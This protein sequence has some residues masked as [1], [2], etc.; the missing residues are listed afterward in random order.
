MRNTKKNKTTA[1]IICL[2]LLLQNTAIQPAHAVNSE[3]ISINEICAKNTAY[4]ANDGNYFD[5][6][7]LYNNGDSSS[8]ISGWGLS[9]QDDQPFKY[10][11]P[12]GTQIAAGDRIIVFCD[13][14]AAANN[15]QI[16]PFGLSASG[17][18]IVLTK[19]NGDTAQSV[20]FDALEADTSYGQYPEGSG[21]YFV[22]SCSPDKANTAPE[23]I[24]SVHEPV[25]SHDSGFYDNDFSLVLT[26]DKDC[27]I[28]YTTDG[29]DPSPEN[30]LQYSEP[31]TIT[32]MSD[33]E[34]RLSARTDIVP[35]NADKPKDKVDKAAVIR[36]VS[37]DS[38]GQASDIVT[39]TFFVGKTNSGYYKDM[40]VVSLITDPDNLFD[41]DKG[42]YCLGKIY[43]E[44]RGGDRR[45]PWELKANYSMKGREWERP[46]NFTMF[47]NG[48][49]V[50]EQ[51]IGIRIKGNYSR[52]LP[53]KSFNLY[54]RKE[55]GEEE[56][57]YD[58]FSGKAVKAKN[59]KTIKKYDGLTLRNGGNDNSSAFFRD[60]INQTLIADR[61]FAKQAATECIVF[62]DGE[63]W[64]IYQMMEKINSS[65]FSQHYG[66]DENSVAMIENGGLE[67]GNDSDLREWDELCNN[68][69]NGSISYDEFCK[70][71]DV[72][73]FIDYFASQIYWCNADWPQ[74]NYTVWRSDV[75]DESNPYADG[76]WR[77]AMFDT[78]SGQGL[79]GSQDK[80]FSA[81]QFKRIRESNCQLSKLFNGLINSQEF[82]YQFTRT[83]MDLSNQNFAADRT[84]EVIDFY[85]NNYTQQISDTFARFYSR[86]MSGDNAARHFKEALNTVTEFYSKRPSYAERTTRSAMKISSEP[87]TLSIKNNSNSGSIDLNT[88]KL[89]NISSWSGNYHSDYELDLTAK[90][91]EGKYFAYWNINDAE[92]TD[93]DIYSASVSLKL[94]S[95]ATVEAVYGD[96]SKPAV[97]TTAAVTTAKTTAAATVTTTVNSNNKSGK[98]YVG[99]V[100]E[101]ENFDIKSGVEN[102]NCS[103]GGMDAA[104]IEKGDYIGFNNI[105]L[106]NAGKID[107]RIG[108]NGARAALEVRIDSPD[109][110]VI[111]RMDVRSSDGWQTWNTQSCSIEKTQ[112]KHDLYF[113][114]TGEEGYLFN[115]NWWRLDSPVTECIIGDA[116]SDGIV[117]VFDFVI[118]KNAIENGLTGNFGAAD[119]NGD[120]AV[121]ETDAELI[122]KY[123]MGEI[124]SF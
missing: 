60:T 74:K 12:N 40:K 22:L 68:V 100:I 31:I 6:I 111:G 33:T 61:D 93:G 65:Y 11:F 103:E 122:K 62:V 8:D 72:Q 2:A 16:A 21:E 109:G 75:I 96:G 120:D 48:Q 37:V 4:A 92:I 99:K 35:D 20:S 69:G 106:S 71:V 9:D 66:V 76:K 36:A 45:N 89:G 107:F 47:E 42:I 58:F 94:T 104:Y 19:P 41:K 70:K 63:F 27:T 95:D 55:Y 114:F 39:K 97:I 25:F 50:I 102:E 124:K 3:Q 88:L 44:N 113:V 79:Y 5:W 84:K 67:E 26:A 24:N 108:S 82:R 30:S 123:I 98:K 32:D 118:I 57:E 112:G 53:Q 115:I 86:S 14:D 56:F 52:S 23:G 7:E 87:H 43:E 13:S 15:A 121:N 29:S 49:K 105:D 91:V 54:T 64:G 51:N 110:K 116:N 73:G 34:N 81:D 85:K 101:A 119:I 117:D 18:K 1:G 77:M 59:G 46:A 10:V 90:P 38:K 78:E 80:S 83:M 17:E 28:Y